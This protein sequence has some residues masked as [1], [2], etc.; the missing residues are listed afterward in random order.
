MV[1]CTQISASMLEVEYFLAS[2]MNC[3]P[4]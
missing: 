4:L 2:N 3:L 1:L